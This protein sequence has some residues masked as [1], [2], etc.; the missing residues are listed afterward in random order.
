MFSQDFGELEMDFH[1]M[2]NGW[3]AHGH[4]VTITDKGRKETEAS[5]LYLVISR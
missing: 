5:Y 4:Y 1:S 2:M 3:S